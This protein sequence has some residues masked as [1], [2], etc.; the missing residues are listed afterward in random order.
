V[1]I[2]LLY[3]AEL[4]YRKGFLNA[5][6]YGG[7]LKLLSKHGLNL[8]CPYSAEEM[9]KVMLSDKKMSGETLSFVVI[10]GIGDCRT[11]DIPIKNLKE[12]LEFR[13]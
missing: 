12:F 1:A 5:E 6:S 8:R 13:I 4:S 10:R 7:I 9:I 11:E 2:G 3:I